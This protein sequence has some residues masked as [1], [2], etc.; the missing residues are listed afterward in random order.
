[1]SPIEKDR[2][3]ALFDHKSRW[4]QE[5]EARDAEG[6]S[7]H[8]DSGEA[9]AWD[10]VGALCQ[11]FGWTRATELFGQLS[12]HMLRGINRFSRAGSPISAMVA[13]VDFNDDPELDFAAFLAKLQRLPVS[14]RQAALPPAL[15][16]A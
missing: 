11:L 9:V 13:L 8:F 1:M 12:R 14:G 5:A 6:E 3:L 2:L 7:V 10:L 4:C 15:G 16:T